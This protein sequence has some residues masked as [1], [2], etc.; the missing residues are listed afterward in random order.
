MTDERNNHSEGKRET[1]IEE[2]K[3]A[4]EL[5][6]HEDN[7]NW[8]KLNHLLYINAG[9]VTVMGF[10]L[11]ACGPDSPMPGSPRLFIGMVSLIG[12]IVSSALGIALWFGIKYMHS[13]KDRV[14]DVEEALVEYGGRHIVSAG[15]V[16]SQP[17]GFLKR[18]PTTLMLRLV[19]IVLSLVWLV[20]FIANMPG[21]ADCVKRQFSW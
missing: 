16:V 20:I 3:V 9:L 19:P 6:T 1:L 21:V 17:K 12:F 14:V 8:T 7:L 4:V 13:R 15:S 5:Y 10:I 2:Y 11:K 18:S